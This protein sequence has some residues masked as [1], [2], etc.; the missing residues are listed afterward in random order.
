LLTRKYGFA[1]DGP[2]KM[3]S[4]G[5]RKEIKKL[6]IDMMNGEQGENEMDE[7]R[8]AQMLKRI[9]YNDKTEYDYHCKRSLNRFG[10]KP[11][12]GKRWLTPAEISEYALRELG[13]D[14]PKD[15]PDVDKD[16]KAR[17]ILREKGEDQFE[18]S[19]RDDLAGRT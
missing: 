15:V 5:S 4:E 11:A 14:H 17:D 18:I 12:K 6:K 9:F 19:A 1:I 2:V 8:L 3:H 10:E 7:L 13:Y 16:E